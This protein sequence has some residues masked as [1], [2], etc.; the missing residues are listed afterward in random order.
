LDD[1]KFICANLNKKFYKMEKFVSDIILDEQSFLNRQNPEE[2]K[3]LK[4]KINLRKS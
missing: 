1:I 4:D 3:N 2:N